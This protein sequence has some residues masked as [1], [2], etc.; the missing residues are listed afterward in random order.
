MLGASRH[1]KA[2]AQIDAICARAAQG[3]MSG[4]ILHLKDYGDLAPT[5]AAF[6]RLL[7]LTDAYIRE[8]GASLSFA[9]QGKYFRPFLPQGMVGNFRGG[10][11][12]INGARQTMEAGA[13]ETARLQAEVAELVAAA[14]AGDLGGRLSLDGKDGFMRRLAEGINILVDRT[15]TAFGEVARVIA[16]LANGDLSKQMQGDYQ[17]VFAT[18][19]QD[20]NRTIAALRD[21]AQQLGRAAEAVQ[22]AADE[23]D[24]GSRDLAARTESQA[25]TLE[26]TA[27]AMHQITETVRQ[28]ADNAQAASQLTAAAR[29][30][31][32]TGGAVV[33]EAVQ[34]MGRI[35]QSA[36]KIGDIVGLIDEIAFQTNLLALNASVEAA[37]AGE[38]GK[39]FAVVAQEVRALAQR[40]ANAS[41]D[42]KT[43]I[44]ESGAEVRT[45]ADL[46]NRAGASLGDIVSAVK[47][48]SDIVAEIAAASAEQSRSL[49]EA[50]TAVASLDQMTQRNSA[51]VEETSASARTL[52][53]LARRLSG[54]VGFFRLSA[55]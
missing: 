44:A 6:N 16:A 7:D 13:Q 28:T 38:A 48:A 20:T 53:D 4:R 26:Q 27:A 10:A 9:A 51:L 8:S 5:L 34:A 47:K 12:I 24:E 3:D 36:A 49:D 55:G 39:G 41:K 23:I 14:A 2:L 37:R 19:Q 31:A 50:N 11:D 32:E 18:V 29:D 17:G 54:I 25:A 52:A 40:S 35:E 46:V 1:R 45:G 30:T 21:V 42:I 33:Q 15:G 22:A 43:L